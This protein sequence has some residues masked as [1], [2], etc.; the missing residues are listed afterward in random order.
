MSD[1][2]KD[3]EV[4]LE[5][6]IAALMVGILFYFEHYLGV[7]LVVGLCLAADLYNR[8]SVGRGMRAK[9]KAMFGR[10][11]EKISPD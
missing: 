4:L 8:T 11:L 6:V 2:K 10:K 3:R 5:V 7:L 9:L 1:Q